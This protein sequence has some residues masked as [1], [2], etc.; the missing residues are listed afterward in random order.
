M[1][2]LA[3]DAPTEMSV[4]LQWDPVRKPKHYETVDHTSIFG[5]AL[6]NL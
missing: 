6:V 5:S 2:A 1:Q 4:Q 3:T